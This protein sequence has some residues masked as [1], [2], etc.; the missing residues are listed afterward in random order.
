MSIRPEHREFFD[1]HRDF[2]ED[3]VKDD[4]YVDAVEGVTKLEDGNF[5]LSGHT[6]EFLDTD[7]DYDNYYWYFK[8]D[9]TIYRVNGWYNSYEGRSMDGFDP[10]EVVKKTRQETYWEEV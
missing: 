5:S 7:R 6:L 2:L 3:F 4:G 9:D 8:V 1:D 10:V